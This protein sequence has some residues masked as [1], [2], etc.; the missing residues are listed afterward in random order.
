MKKFGAKIAQEICQKNNSG[1]K[2]ALVV[3]LEGELGAG[4]TQFVKGLAK[5]LGFPVYPA[6]RLSFSSL[7]RS[8]KWI[9]PVLR[10]FF[11]SICTV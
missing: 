6:P 1:R 10:I 8:K 5:Y 9:A 4:K 11:M 7:I 2:N 3:A